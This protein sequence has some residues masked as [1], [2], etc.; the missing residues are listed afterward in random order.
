MW[1]ESRGK[2]EMER[3]NRIQRSLVELE[4][5][6]LTHGLDAEGEG[7]VSDLKSLEYDVRYWGC[8]FPR[9]GN[10]GNL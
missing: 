8:L 6:G 7:K 1:Y 5:L 2:L 10:P 9:P 4:S 3:G